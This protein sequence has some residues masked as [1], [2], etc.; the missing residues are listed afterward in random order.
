MD[1]GRIYIWFSFDGDDWVYDTYYLDSCEDLTYTWYLNKKK[2]TDSGLYLE[3]SRN[4]K[5]IK[6]I[7]NFT[8]FKR[9]L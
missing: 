3:I 9:D 5:V 4:G 6:T 2:S 1:E 7:T 8:N